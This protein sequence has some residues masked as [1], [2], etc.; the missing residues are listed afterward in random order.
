MPQ[1]VLQYPGMDADR[2]DRGPVL[3]VGWLPV[4]LSGSS[5][6]LKADATNRVRHS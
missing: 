1:L 4:E 6:R 5:L 2:L 3:E